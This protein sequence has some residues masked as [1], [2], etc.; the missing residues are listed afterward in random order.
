MEIDQPPHRPY[1]APSG[2]WLMRMTWNDL[3]FAHWRVEAA[4]MRARVPSGLEIEEFG[5]SA[6]LGVVPF[7]MS[8]VRA[9]WLPPVPG[10]AVFPELN[11]R[12]YVRSTRDGRPGVW[13]FSL[14]ASS[15]VAVWGARTVFGLAYMN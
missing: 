9:K 7:T 10:A 11:V 3:L 6:W 1:P 8:G 12:T 13:F 14:D 2:P 4:A 5:G 15:R